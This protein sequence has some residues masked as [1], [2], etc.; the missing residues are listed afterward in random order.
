MGSK[1]AIKVWLLC[2]VLMVVNVDEYRESSSHSNT[3]EA[4]VA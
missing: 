2:L 4:S 1:L 3:P